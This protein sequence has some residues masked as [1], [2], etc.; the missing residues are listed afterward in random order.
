MPR[1]SRRSDNRR[2]TSGHTSVLGSTLGEASSR[3]RARGVPKSGIPSQD[4]LK[5]AEGALPDSTLGLGLVD[6]RK[7]GHSILRIIAIASGTLAG[8]LVIVALVL[9]VLSHTSVFKI[10]SIETYDTEHVSAEN[11][12]QL[13]RL[14]EGATFLNVD[15]EE[16]RKS[17]L[18]N[19]WIADVEIE[20]V[21]PDRLLVRTRERKVG[22]LV[23]MR[24]GGLCWLLGDDGVWIEPLRVEAEESESS[25]DA[26]LAEAERLGVVMVS[27]VPA[28]VSPVAGTAATDEALEAVFSFQEQFPDEFA[29][30]VVS[31]SAPDE[32]GI[33]CIL[34]SGVEVSMGSPTNVASKVAVAQEILK[35]FAGQV[36]YVNVR[37]P[38]RPTYRRVESSYV[39]EGTG[40]TGVSVDE[41]SNFANLPQREPEEE[42][43]EEST[44][45]YSL[46]GSENY[47]EYSDDYSSTGYGYD[48][49][50][51]SSTYGSQNEYDGG[52]GET[53]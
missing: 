41:E 52:H 10:T 12:A 37:I 49:V 9:A 1:N 29:K 34:K 30:E 33:S 31:F 19:P 27:G 4:S 35:E 14:E 43:E 2:K 48:E 45:G 53:Y 22:A 6:A 23:A 24:A 36:T 44:D 50:G 47:D 51:N 7:A 21:F 46:D 8:L 26:A 25:V 11:V 38:S 40:A 32:E 3:L 13:I 42:S 17:I 28:T 16:V 20:N 15:T 18:N 39:H 5:V